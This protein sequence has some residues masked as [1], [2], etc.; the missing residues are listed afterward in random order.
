[1][2]ESC[3]QHHGMFQPRCV[4]HRLTPK[5]T[6]TKYRSGQRWLHLVKAWKLPGMV[7]PQLLCKVIR[8]TTLPREADLP[9]V[10]F[11]FKSYSLGPCYTPATTGKSLA[12]SSVCYMIHG[13]STSVCDHQQNPQ[14]AP[15]LHATPRV[16]TQCCTAYH[17]AYHALGDLHAL[18]S[19]I[20]F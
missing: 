13:Y 1:M 18:P 16:T 8:A 12:P 9:T 5:Q 19:A 4:S 2:H 20:I 17:E 7:I 10:L 6:V 11:E 15:N 3:C 14:T